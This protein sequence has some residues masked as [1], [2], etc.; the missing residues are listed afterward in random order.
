MKFSLFYLNAVAMMSSIVIAC[1]EGN[2]HAALGWLLYC[3]WCCTI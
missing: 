1:V 3:G 2:F